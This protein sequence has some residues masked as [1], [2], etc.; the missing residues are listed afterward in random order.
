MW[1]KEIE[2]LGRK[3]LENLQFEKLKTTLEA[4]NA[5]PFYKKFF[6]DNNTDLSK[7]KSLEHLKD[8][9]FTAKNDL[10]LS[11]PDG[12][13]V[14]PK[15]EIVRI[16]ASSGTTGKSTVIFYSA[17]DISDWAD[18][19]AR[20]MVATGTSKDDVFQNMMGYGLF[21]GGL[22]LHYGAERLGAMVIP[23]ATRK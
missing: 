16:H 11:Y 1:N 7:I 4:A 20:C 6:K 19:V 2:S 8:I 18:L 22:G 17:K 13:V 3:D 21:T 9:P 15:S 5:T 23:A 14:M 12:M 10:R